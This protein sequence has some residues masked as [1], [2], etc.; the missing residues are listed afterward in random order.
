[1]SGTASFM[2]A[3]PVYYAAWSCIFLRSIEL[4]ALDRRIHGDVAAPFVCQVLAEFEILA[5]H[6]HLGLALQFPWP[7]AEVI[8]VPRRLRR[9]RRVGALERGVD[10]HGRAFA[11]VARAARPVPE[12]LVRNHL[13]VV[14]GLAAVGH[15]PEQRIGV[16][17]L[18]VLV[19]GDD[20]F[21]GKTV[22]R[23][24]AVERAPDFA[25]GC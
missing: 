1:M 2:S 19:D 5:L 8:T 6:R 12:I 11:G 15:G 7:V 17:G 24:G 18:D 22:Q 3:T 21:A 10:Q 20:P 23:G 25:L 13:E 16:F 4:V 9:D 14:L